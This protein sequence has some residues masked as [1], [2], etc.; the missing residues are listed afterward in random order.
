MSKDPKRGY[1]ER[2]RANGSG[3][4]TH[5]PWFQ[6][7]QFDLDMY[8]RTCGQSS[9]V[10]SRSVIINTDCCGPNCRAQMINC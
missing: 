2:A 3:S 6:T 9:R 8:G 5:P 7:D 4:S 1:G 10:A